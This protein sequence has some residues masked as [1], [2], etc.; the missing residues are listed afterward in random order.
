MAADL[1]SCDGLDLDVRAVVESIRR[2][3]HQI[4]FQH[5]AVANIALQKMKCIFPNG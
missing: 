5:A 2:W 1:R 4:G 3:A